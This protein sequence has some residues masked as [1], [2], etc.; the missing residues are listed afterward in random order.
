MV[1]GLIGFT[2][3]Y[4]GTLAIGTCA[5][6]LVLDGNAALV[7]KPPAALASSTADLVA[8]MRSTGH[9]PFNGTLL[10]AFTACLSTLTNIG[11]GLSAVGPTRHYGHLPVAGK[12]IL[13]LLMLMG[14]LELFPVL[15]LFSIR[16]WRK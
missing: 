9:D 1:G 14:R 12:W 2:V 15:I 10:T 7:V 16:T 11:P 8:T 4:L 6:A 5:L 13:C 3:I